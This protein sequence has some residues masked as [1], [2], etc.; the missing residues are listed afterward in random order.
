[1]FAILL[2]VRDDGDREILFRLDVATQRVGRE[3]GPRI[4][5]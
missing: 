1:L 3:K 5:R 2:V 4:R